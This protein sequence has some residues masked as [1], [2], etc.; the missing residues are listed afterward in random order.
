MLFLA[1]PRDGVSNTHTWID[2]TPKMWEELRALLAVQNPRTIA[3]N[4]HPQIAFSSGLHAGELDALRKGLGKGWAERFVSEPMLAVGY[5]ATMPTSR[6]EWYHKLQ[7]TAWAVIDEAFSEKVIS[8]GQ[9]TTVVGEL[10]QRSLLS[11]AAGN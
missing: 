9:T 6:R 2:N 5:I 8:P 3:I 11:A 10:F 1:D 4:T 7:S